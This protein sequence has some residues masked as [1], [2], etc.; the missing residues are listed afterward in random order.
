MNYG[1][2]LYIFSVVSAYVSALLER[3]NAD[4]PLIVSLIGR[5][6]K[7]FHNLKI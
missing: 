5:P 3:Q 7:E 4:R 1:R 6:L 2:I